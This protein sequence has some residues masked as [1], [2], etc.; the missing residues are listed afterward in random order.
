MNSR[1]E[2][3]NGLVVANLVQVSGFERRGDSAGYSERP[4]K[5]HEDASTWKGSPTS[6][7]N[8]LMIRGGNRGLGIFIES[9]GT[10]LRH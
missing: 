7:N 9:S 8:K 2:N 5:Y 6:E 1:C 10:G 4:R 3:C